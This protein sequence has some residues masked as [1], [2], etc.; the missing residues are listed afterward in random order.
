MKLR[1]LLLGVAMLVGAAL[2]PMPL[3][4]QAPGCS[5]NFAL[6]LGGFITGCYNGTITELGEDAS[7]QSNQYYWAGT[8]AGS[9]GVNNSPNAPGTFM[10]NN[11]CGSGGNG[12]FAFCTGN[13]AKP[14]V[15]VIGTS[16]ELVLGLM[17]PDNT[18]GL[19]FD[20]VYSGSQ[21]RNT[22]PMPAGY[23]DVLLQLTVAGVDDPG[24]FL[25]G[26]EDMNTGCQTRTAVNNNRFAEEDLGNG[27]LL[28]TVLDNCTLITPGGNSDSD[29]NDSYM[30]F[31]IGGTGIPLSTVPEPGA[32][33][34]MAIGLVGM[35][36]TGIRRRRK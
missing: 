3:T 31:D 1:S 5:Y 20:W 25:F 30:L 4:A 22:V 36:G 27:T 10:F 21:V 18:T 13:F 6:G 24:M 35:V 8:Y 15:P 32:M 2:R 23:Q 16:G 12:T 29:F 7:F 14:L 34:L 17:V 9:A 26:W 33:S 19:G 11:N 28:N